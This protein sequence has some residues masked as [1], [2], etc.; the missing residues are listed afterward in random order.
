MD[1]ATKYKGGT[2][3][4]GWAEGG[5]P[6]FVSTR[7]SFSGIILY[8]KVWLFCPLAFEYFSPLHKKPKSA[9]LNSISCVVKVA[10]NG[11]T[12]KITFLG[13]L[14]QMFLNAKSLKISHHLVEISG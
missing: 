14:K 10:P 9:I 6:Y 13:N 2:D 1:Q 3:Q 8:E 11:S 12:N 4:R 7:A 5:I